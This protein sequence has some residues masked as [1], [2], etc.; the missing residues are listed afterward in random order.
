MI[1]PRPLGRALLSTPSQAHSNPP[2]PPMYGAVT[3][4]LSLDSHRVKTSR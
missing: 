4:Q 1:G 3:A 2:L